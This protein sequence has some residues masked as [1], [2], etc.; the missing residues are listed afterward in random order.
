MTKLTPRAKAYRALRG[1][2]ARFANREAIADGLVRRTLQEV[3]DLRHDLYLSMTGDELRA[4]ENRDREVG[5][6]D[7]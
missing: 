7:R 4:V 5:Y 2:L 1:V 6:V 3:D